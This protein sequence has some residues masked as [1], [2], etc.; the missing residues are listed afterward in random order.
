MNPGLRRGVAKFSANEA[1]EI[2]LRVDE[3]SARRTGIAHGDV[4]QQD[5]IVRRCVANADPAG[6]FRPAGHDAALEADRLVA[7]GDVELVAEGVDDFTSCGR[8]GGGGATGGGG[9]DGIA[10]LS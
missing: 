7:G 6:Q 3:G 4:D 5:F 2:P 1:D 9:S 10:K 8:A